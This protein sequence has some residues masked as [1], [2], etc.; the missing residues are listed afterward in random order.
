MNKLPL[1]EK[2]RA[3]L[4]LLPLLLLLAMTWWLSLQVQPA[5]QKQSQLRHDVD[6]VIENFS[7]TLLDKDGKQRHILSA[8]KLWHYPDDDTTHMQLPRF[9]SLSSGH[10]Y[11]HASSQTGMLSSKGDEVFL[12]DEVTLLRPATEVAGEQRFATDHLHIVPDKDWAESD[13]AI[14]AT[15]PGESLRAVGMELDNKARTVL[16]QSRVRA[17]YEPAQH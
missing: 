14:V 15:A 6:F 4:P 16:L 13:R 8:K 5:A 12:Y 7:A 17:S 11:V 10:P 1:I 2:A 9:T 3:W